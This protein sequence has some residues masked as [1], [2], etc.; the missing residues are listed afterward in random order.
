MFAATT[1]ISF[2]QNNSRALPTGGNVVAG[3]ATITQS[4]LQVNINQTSQRA[5]VT[6]D[7]FNVGK[8]ATVSFNQPNASAVT[9]NRV[10]GASASVIDGA[11]RANGQVILVNPNGVTFGKGAQVDA[12]GVV[13]ST[14]NISNKDFMDG[15][16]TYSGGSTGSVV[17]QGTISTNSKDGYI[18]LLAPEV[19]NE[20]YLLAQKGPG[21]TVAMA[22]GEKITLD[23]RGDQL[24][25]VRVDQATYKGLIEN[26]RLVEV[27]GG[28]IVIAA[29][30][31]TRLMSTTINNT[32]V[33]SASSAVDRGG[34]VEFRASNINQ[35]G[36]VAANGSGA[37]TSGGT[38]TMVGDN[39]TLASGSKS[40]A[41]GS[42]NG[43]TIN[44]G[45]SGVTYTQNANGTRTNVVANDLASTATITQDALVDASSTVLGNGGQINIWS[46][47][48]TTV[49]GALKAMGGTFGGNGGFVETSSKTQLVIAPTA[50]VDT[51]APNGKVGQWLLDPID[52]TIDAAVARVISLALALNNVVIEVNANTTACPSMGGCTQN[53]S[54]NLTIASGADILKQG[55][56]F[57]SLTL[58]AS[59]MFALNANIVGQNLNVIINSSIAYLNVGTTI[60]AT[61]VTVQ[62]QSIYASGSIN[63]AGSNTLG[64]AIS[65]LAQ[66]LYISGRLNVSASNSSTSNS[67]ST[68]LT[69]NGTVLRQEDLPAF[70][71][72][73][74]NLNVTSNTLN[75]VYSATSANDAAYVPLQ[76][77][78]TNVI[79]LNATRELIV[80]SGAQIQA[81]G[82]SGFASGTGGTINFV[83]PSLT[84][85]SGSLIQ[86]N[87]NNGPGGAIAISGDVINLVGIIEASGS[88][89]GSFALT[90]NRLTIDNAAVIQTNG[91]AGPGGTIALNSSQDIQINQALIS[92]N[93]NTDGGSIRIV[94]NAGNLNIQNALIQASGSNGR[95]GS[96]GIA[97][98]NQTIL[99]GTT[100]E[101]I[102]FNQGGKILIGNDAKNGT[103]PFSIYSSIDTNSIIKANQSDLSSTSIGGFI[104]TSAHTLSLLGAI[105]AGRGGM[106]LIDPTEVIIDSATATLINT[107]LASS[108]VTIQAG[109]V[110]CSVSCANTASN[111]NG[112]IWVAS[113]ISWTSNK[114]L[115]LK[116]TGN[117]YVDANINVGSGGGLYLHYGGSSTAVAPTV[118]TAYYLGSGKNITFAAT[119]G[120]LYQGNTSY[121]LIDGTTNV[122]LSSSVNYALIKDV[123]SINCGGA[124]YAGYL[125][126][127]MTN[128]TYQGI[129]DGLGHTFNPTNQGVTGLYLGGALGGGLGTGLFA[130]LNG[131]TIR[132]LTVNIYAA[133]TATPTSGIYFGGI[134]GIVT[135][136]TT[137]TNV[138]VTGTFALSNSCT[139]CD[140]YVGGLVGNVSAGNL[141]INGSTSSLVMSGAA[142][143]A[144]YKSISIGGLV[145]GVSTS[146][147]GSV[148]NV[149]VSI[150]SSSFTGTVIGGLAYGGYTATGGII[151][152][153]NESTCTSL[154]C[155][156]LTNVLVTP[157]TDYAANYTRGAFVGWMLDA[158]AA[159]VTN[160]YTTG[161]AYSNATYYNTSTSSNITHSGN[162]TMS[163]LPT[164]FTTQYWSLGSGGNSLQ[165]LPWSATL[166]NLTAISTGGTGASPAAWTSYST[167]L[168]GVLPGNINT[169]YV[170]VPVGSYVGFT[171]SSFTQSAGGN[172][173]SSSVPIT[174]NGALSVTASSAFAISNSMSGIG[175]FTLTSG[176]LTL[177]A[178]NTYAGSTTINA[179]TLKLGINNAIAGSTSLLMADSTNFDLNGYST[180]IGS[181]A[182][183]GA[184]S[185]VA[186]FNNAT[187]TT[188]T[189]TL[190]GSDTT[191]AGVIKDN[192]SGTG[193]V[194]LTLN[195]GTFTLSGLNTYS[196]TSTIGSS[197]ILALGATN[198]LSGA[199]SVALS[200]VLNLNGYSTS[201]GGLS[202]AGIVTNAHNFIQTGLVLYFD[203]GNIQSWTGSGTTVYNLATGSTKGGDASLVG[204]PTYDSANQAITLNSTG[205]YLSVP[206]TNLSDFTTGLTILS[207]ANLGNGSVWARIIDFG[208][209]AQSNNIL[210]ARA[211]TTNNLAFQIYNG[212]NVAMSDT[213]NTGTAVTNNGYGYYA[214]T[215]TAAGNPT[216]YVG[217]AS[218]SAVID[219]GAIGS[220]A[221]PQNITRSNNYLGRSNWVDGATYG[222][223]VTLLYSTALS[224]SQ[225]ATANTEMGRTISLATLTV[226]AN[227]ATSTFTGSIKDGNAAIALVKKG[228]GTQTFSSALTYTGGTTISGGILQA[229][230]ASSG[231]VTNGPFGTG[232][233]TVSSGYTLDLNGFNIANALTL[234]GAGIG[235]NGALINSSATAVTAS[236]AV[237]I[238][239]ATSIGGTGAITFGGVISASTNT[240]TFVNSPSITAINT[241]NSIASITITGSSVALK[242]TASL[243]L[244]SSSLTG[245][246]TL[247]TVAANADIT[248][249]GAI[250]NN[251][252]GNTLTLMASR[253]VLISAPISGA[254]GKSLT[255]NFYSDVDN[256]GGGGF[257]STV[258][259]A[260]V[261]TFGG[262]ITIRGGTTD[263]TSGC[264][265]AYSCIAGYA[266]YGSSQGDAIGVLIWSSLNAAGGNIAV[267]GR[268]NPTATTAGV[269]IHMDFAGT[270]LSTTGTGTITLNGVSTG[271]QRGIY[272]VSGDISA[273][274]GLISITGTSLSTSAYTG[275]RMNAGSITSSGALSIAGTGGSSEY[276]VYIY[277]AGSIVVSG[278]ITI[279]GQ[280]AQAN[281]G[282]VI[283]GSKIIQSTAGNISLT[284]SGGS[285][286]LYINASLIAGNNQTTPTAGGTITIN[287]TGGTDY[288]FQINAGSLISYGAISI[289]AVGSASHAFRF[290]G[291]GGKVKSA[292]NITISATAGTWGLT[293]YNDTFIQ[294]TSGNIA[295]T[296]NGSNG[297]L[298]MASTGG[299]YASSNTSTPT[300][301]P[302]AGGT[303]IISATGATQ[304]GIQ[305]AA[306]SLVSFGAMNITA[307]GAGGYQ[308]S[309]I[310]GAGTFTAVGNI[311]IDTAT[312]G[313]Q[314][315]FQF[316]GSRVMQ[317][318]AGNISITAVGNYGMYANGSIVASNDTTNP[319]TATPTLGGTLTIIATGRTQQGFE[320][321]AGSLISY[322]AMSITG[323]ATGA[324]KGVNISGA[325]TMKAV[326]SIT[327][328]AA[329]PGGDWAFRL[330]D[331]RIMQST[332]GN[333][334]ITASGGYGIY[335]YG[336][337]IVAGNDTTTPTSGGSITI[338]STSSANDISGAALRIDVDSTKI[339]AYGDINIYANGAPAGLNVANQQGHGVILYGN[340]QTIRSY[341][342]DLMIT[343]YANHAD[344]AV[345]GWLNTSGGISLWST[346]DILRAYG[347]VTLKGVSMG[348]IGVFLGANNLAGG[349]VTADTGNIV[350]NAL[351]NSGY[352]AVYVRLPVAATLGS[353]SI[354][355]A[356]SGAGIY[357]DA[358]SGA[359]SAKADINM[360]GYATSGHGIYYAAGPV[361]SSNGNINIYGYTSSTNTGYYGT[362]SNAISASAI[363]GSVTFQGSTISSASTGSGYLVNAAATMSGGTPNIPAPIFA[364]ADS[365]NP[366]YGATY[367]LYWT[368][369]ITANTTTG[370]I[371]LYAKAPYVSGV[372]TAYGL[373]LGTANQSY[374]LTGSNAV[375]SVLAGSIGTGSLSYQT[376]SN[377]EIGALS[378]V[379]GFTGSGLTITETATLTQAK[380]IS[381]DTLTLTGSGGVFV[382]SQ[383]NTVNTSITLNSG[384]L[385]VGNSSA[386]GGT[387]K[388]LTMAASTILQANA[389][390]LT[391]SNPIS[392]SGAA[393]INAPSTYTFTLSGILSGASGA[394]TINSPTS[395]TGTVILTAANTYGSTTTVSAGTLQIGT[396]GS[397]SATL[398]ASASYA[399]ALSV[400]SGA[401]FNWYSSATQSFSN[402]AAG[403]TTGAINFSST[404][405]NA[406]TISGDQAFTGVVN[407]SQP[408][409]MSGGS[410]NAHTGLGN[411]Q[412]VH[413]SNGGTITLSTTADNAFLGYSVT[414]N[415]I[416]DQGGL[417]TTNSTSSYSYHMGTITLNGGTLAYG[418]SSLV[419]GGCAVACGTYNLDNKVTVTAN[420]T[421]SAIG[422]LLSQAGG[423]V[424]DVASGITL[425][426]SGILY[427]PTTFGDTGFIK[428]GAGTMVLQGANTYTGATAVNAG[429][430]AVTNATGLGSTAAGV[431]VAS[432]AILD[433]QNVTVGS[434][435]ITLNGGTIATSTGTSSLSGTVALG[436][437]NSTVS[438]A[439]TQLTLSGVISGANGFTKSG[440]GIL[441]LSGNNTYTGTTAINAGTLVAANTGAVGTSAGGVSITSGATFALQGGITIASAISASGT[442][443]GNA[444]A[445]LNNSGTNSITGLVTLG[446]A[447]TIGSTAG[448]LTFD[449]ASG[450]AFTGTYNLTFTGAGNTTVIDP[451]SIS[452]G[453]LTKSGSGVLTLS[454]LNTYTGAT[455]IS[456][457]TV[458]LG[459]SSS[460]SNSPLG[461]V[462]SGTTVANGAALDLAGFSMN[463]LE[464]LTLSG[465]GVSNSGALYNSSTTA[466]VYAGPITLA[467]DTS[468]KNTGALTISGAISG[469]YALTVSNTGLLT[470]GSTVGSSTT[471][472]A[473]LAVSGPVNLY[474][475]VWT[476]GAQTYSGD[477]GVGADIGLNSAS[478]GVTI[479][480]ALTGITASSLLYE[481]TTANRSGDAVVYSVNNSGTVSG[482][483]NRI[484]Y[485]MEV[486]VGGTLYYAQVTFDA[487]ANNLTAADLRI[488]DLVNQLVVQKI[489]NNMVVSSNQTSGI[490]G[491]ASSVITGSG[492]TGYLE[493]WGWN[494]S[495]GAS[496]PAGVPTGNVATYDYNDTPAYNGN[497]GSFQV[498]NITAGSTQTVLAWNNQPASATPD[499]GLGNYIGSATGAAGNTDWTFT[500]S[501]GASL[502]TTAFKLQ[503]LVN[504]VTP[505]LKINAGSGAVNIA[506]ATSGLKTLTVNS[507]AATSAISGAI[508]NPAI[509]NAVATTLTKQGSGAL[510]L[511]A[512]NTYT[513]ATNIDAGA[514]I[515]RN[516]APSTSTSGF[517]GPGTLAIESTSTSFT[518]AFSTSGWV[519]NSN[520]GG[521]TL[522]KDGN[523]KDITIA[524]ATSIAGPINIYG[525]AIAINAALA[526]IGTNTIT[527]KGS[528]DVTDG[529]N[530]YVSAS[531]LLLLGGNIT[532]DNSASNAIGTLAAS[533]VS[534]LTYVDKD[535]LIIATVGG[536]NGISASGA[537]G[538]STY[539]GDLT[540]SKPVV[541]TNTTSSAITLTAGSNTGAGTATGGNVIITG[542]V[543]TATTVQTLAS[544]PSYVWIRSSDYSGDLVADFTANSSGWT[545]NGVGIS[546]VA[547]NNTFG[548]GYS[549]AVTQSANVYNTQSYT[550][551]APTSMPAVTTGSNGRAVIYT[552][553]VSGSTGVTTYI[554]SGT[555]NFR[556]K[557]NV[558]TANFTTVLGT[559]GK[560]AVYREA[561]TAT[562]TTDNQ[563][564]TYGDTV[565]TLTGATSGLVNGDAA[566]YGLNSPLYSTASKIKVGSYTIS[567]SG[568]AGLGYTLSASNG[569]LTVVQKAITVTGTTATSKTYDASM[570]ATI[571]TTSSALTN[572]STS[573]SDNK[574]YT[575]DLLTLVKTGATASYADKNVGTNKAVSVAGFTLTGADAGNYTVTDAS[576][577]TATITA[578]ALSMSGL[579][580]PNSKIYDATTAA[581]V[582]GTPTLA[583]PEAVGAGTTSD[584][585]AY[586]GDTVSIAGT[587][588][589]TYNSKDVASASTVTYSGLS[590]TGA[591]AGNY[592]L[593]IQSPGAATITAKAL[594]M[595]GLSV[596]NSKTYDGT[597]TA[598][599]SG[600]AALGA[601][602]AAGAGTTVDGKAYTGDTVSI[603]GT[604]AAAYNSAH[605]AT[606]TTITYS[607][608]SLTG[609]QAGNYTLTIT[610]PASGTIT[611]ATLTPTITN[612]GVTKTYDGTVSSS[613]TPTYSF[614]GLVSGDT[615]ATITNTGTTYNDAHVANA[616]TVTAAGLV[617]TAITGN[618]SSVAGDYVLDATSKT[619]AGTITRATL[620]PTITNTGVTKTY[621]GTVSSSI[622]PT[623]SFA[624][625][626]SG[627]R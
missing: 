623:Y 594:T 482:S 408:V 394:L 257:K 235:S 350:I 369:N 265:T 33:I 536:V 131:A 596:P 340:Y 389:D 605:V 216:I 188:S 200:G 579:T 239:S 31:A 437:A 264:A 406:V 152:P 534:G 365:V 189:L 459:A 405:T 296:S 140:L 316:D 588:V 378:G 104:E 384:T 584:G 430:L 353:V 231:S 380:S 149:Y 510:I 191:F 88:L 292:S 458:K 617:I 226:G 29:G 606:A 521:L 527:L 99:A 436:A 144:N 162:T 196:G 100:V 620:T 18:A 558:G 106:W 407:V 134:A 467:A 256:T 361:S 599:V 495:Q 455:N 22:S 158:T 164:G 141:V 434:E 435:A 474:G 372:M 8:D 90:A 51:S 576:G 221:I 155:I 299:I 182:T 610:S 569:T 414:T 302:T 419:A 201:I 3:N 328:N 84:V 489:V 327:I 420:S 80:Y 82:T 192:T 416:I 49:A 502:G 67:N 542:S 255:A 441:V 4:N 208:G 287:A 388:P 260:T 269:G 39:I 612:T 422:V 308:G 445:I 272:H 68:T 412:T 288:G 488:P 351:S 102:G 273:G 557:S 475:D 473:S 433:L 278:D 241:G 603:A 571:A 86:A 281:Q 275:Y 167:W 529:A 565:P 409:I 75:I 429:T 608:L 578:K 466:A 573:V 345:N 360:I 549:I 332:A 268:G 101:A 300:T 177:S 622:T 1:Q 79:N 447:T 423:T 376:A 446:A 522:G 103:L 210:F 325:G 2:A 402:L 439:G 518:S 138:A 440:V 410:N 276:G 322:G 428:Q 115:Y 38:I 479:G 504:G 566:S 352:A 555:G 81:N 476:T 370:Q 514:L 427:R 204:S 364:V 540:I 401:T 461:T 199:S 40:V 11:V 64:G 28:L 517:N 263:T 254:S 150:N 349:G 317:S 107:A 561:V 323:S 21:N 114:S 516:D 531:N 371:N 76:N 195:G 95:G 397:S 626:V 17:N 344:G 546:S 341:H 165:L 366:A 301:T 214:A 481:T 381:V 279:N 5:V 166:P 250:T 357:Q 601:A 396:Q 87:G 367:G 497:Y 47:V 202:G 52:L 109:V 315:G 175:S 35:A 124:C 538:I 60:A 77:I 362:Y 391:L 490:S 251:T 230:I 443:M 554:G 248:V 180:T 418:N 570:G 454:G 309:Y 70:I 318:T 556:Y 356:G 595:S 161:S 6:W 185:L 550:L 513:G 30:S 593:T 460:G 159:R 424:F 96:I 533:G 564:I 563:S 386:L 580:V 585:K 611:R 314:W 267:Y 468:I 559:S 485:R 310:Y 426:V 368:G 470:L 181:L 205:N 346:S 147:T 562:I 607:G 277:G 125:G 615:A 625:L 203:P 491:K 46:S 148:S 373:L 10:T 339:I 135:G 283:E 242:T 392:M 219:G 613:I 120:A 449:V 478:G 234:N 586:T 528:G 62:A 14:L 545:Y 602:E 193:T 228:S 568:P 469:A 132:N 338:N 544:T 411:T 496:A 108:D 16:G 500:G 261:S 515:I 194:G 326:G 151:G 198:A 126:Y 236:G 225:V 117:I 112:N 57:T 220:G 209:G 121:T 616:T 12:A 85:Q 431:T 50:S 503:V 547:V 105:N 442:G 223:G 501:N 197:A 335:I 170:V 143:L 61:Q 444:G 36:T 393:T 184:G 614:A 285:K 379:N 243:T 291:V 183:T 55:N 65:L 567:G 627:D 413:I 551:Q 354:S 34:M 286:G 374:S 176:T 619:V 592:S 178:A 222:M 307:R 305:I 324:Y 590:L 363:N 186:I 337:G 42:A 604:A 111:A 598:V 73:Q 78:T 425:T 252:N 19:R 139:T 303:L 110:S 187:G 153:V 329:T 525:G 624:G 342:G 290:E 621:D 471:P 543:G 91:Q 280:N 213:T 541:T 224:A 492:F 331:S 160:A 229:G 123:S 480:G 136:T 43:G 284:G 589:G 463:T 172:I 266:S 600:T 41:T 297:G 93:G 343:G 319:T 452:T 486:N 298:Y 240:I 9:L 333:I 97:A 577:A 173:T 258:A 572:G 334:S 421:M 53:G 400:S 465:T 212:A 59:G 383:A 483:I 535:A 145:G 156:S 23:F 294:S 232:A 129:F 520:L 274:S 174:I 128:Q 526:A 289:T 247:Q 245:A 24:M 330:F 118:G 312:S 74:N 190:S 295:I 116:A 456:A 63:A 321:G 122:G 154:P 347:N 26:K 72:A 320:M 48:R 282:L 511:S 157:Q 313:A 582:S 499:V 44:I 207:K 553:S 169:G 89:G 560:Y 494:Y 119:T 171:G 432:G 237:T 355:G 218:A 417:L 69:Y 493:L 215:L 13:A 348:G 532:L 581:V 477:L 270:V 451:I 246:S 512:A 403:G 37:N 94:S 462:T 618:K 552:G 163:S 506:G 523:T 66:A 484:T 398:G 507:D 609:T 259:T 387:S 179:G 524:A 448:S 519:F 7:S 450:N 415:L 98:F 71:T 359:V 271:A 58:S 574:Y 293:M 306:G 238:S 399:Q 227:N 505:S 382:L 133:V 32:G 54:G 438:V 395:N 249:S 336:G 142:S 358:W 92:A 113:S 464:P 472:L 575:G 498:H 253:D 262:D 539:T 385:K 25:S 244:N 377:L 137:L 233:V 130:A 56:V 27:P 375:I 311:T 591:Q 206:S 487:W 390:L 509:Q 83:A 404:G 457:G 453:G 217:G 597:T 583:A 20:G 304:Y 587:A 15:K 211:G 168:N 146:T 548:P 45:T 508:S 537:I 127:S 530:G